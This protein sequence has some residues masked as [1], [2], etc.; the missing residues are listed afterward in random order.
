MI[1]IAVTTTTAST[2][3]IAAF[4]RKS[5]SSSERTEEPFPSASG[6]AAGKAVSA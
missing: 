4:I 5:F 1:T 2:P 3:T 6:K